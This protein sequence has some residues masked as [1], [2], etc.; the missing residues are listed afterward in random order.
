MTLLLLLLLLFTPYNELQ[1]L[2]TTDLNL[3]V[4]TTLQT[5][6]QLS[7]HTLQR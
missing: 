5:E 4:P 6:L 2:E 1:I 3:T 7:F